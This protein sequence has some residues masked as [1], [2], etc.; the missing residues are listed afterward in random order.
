MSQH[1]I[2]AGKSSFDLIERE[3]F[4]K[5]LQLAPGMTVLDLAWGSTMDVP[6]A[7]LVPLCEAI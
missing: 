6:I 2:G 3:A 4:F 5:A 7:P 1:P